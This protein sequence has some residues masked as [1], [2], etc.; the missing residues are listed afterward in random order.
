MLKKILMVATAVVS[1]MVVVPTISAGSAD[2]RWTPTPRIAVLG[3]E[4]WTAG[5]NGACRGSMHVSVKNDA[6]KPGQVQLTVRS[7]GFTS[8]RCRATLRFTYN[9]AVPPF[10]HERYFGI[11]GTKKRGV[12]LAQKTYRVGSGLNLIAVTS[13]NPA[14][15][16]A[17]WYIAIP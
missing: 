10:A 6:R 17:S 1:L 12:V 13:T 14:Q 15:K 8:D 9:N 7:R 2:A 3:E 11:V 5:N 4:V 16:G